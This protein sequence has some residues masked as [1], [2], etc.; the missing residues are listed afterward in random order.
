MIYRQSGVLGN[1][2]IDFVCQREGETTYFQV[3]LTINET[4]TLEREFGNLQKS[5]ITI[6]RPSS[7]W[8]SLMEILLKVSNRWN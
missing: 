3:A 6:Q 8:T 7:L 5:K 2:E 4:K 1:E